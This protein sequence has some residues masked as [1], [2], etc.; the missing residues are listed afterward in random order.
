MF[1]SIWQSNIPVSI[2]YISSSS[3]L[4][5]IYVYLGLSPNANASM[6]EQVENVLKENLNNFNEMMRI[7]LRLPV[8]THIANLSFIGKAKRHFQAVIYLFCL[9]LRISPLHIFGGKIILFFDMDDSDIVFDIHC[10]IACCDDIIEWNVFWTHYEEIVRVGENGTEKPIS[11]MD[12]IVSVLQKIK[13]TERCAFES[14]DCKFERSLASYLK[15]IVSERECSTFICRL[16]EMLA[17]YY[18]FFWISTVLAEQI[19]QIYVTILEKP[20]DSA[21]VSVGIKH[22]MLTRRSVRSRS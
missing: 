3:P 18:K 2:S 19:Q 22:S 7:V 6:K 11:L 15:T 5:D 21:C 12:L 4:K 9:F 13:L 17:L 14:R 8:T 16:I 1:D 10:Q 20:C